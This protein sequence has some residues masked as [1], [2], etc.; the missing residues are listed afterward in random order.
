MTRKMITGRTLRVVDP[1]I[2]P[3]SEHRLRRLFAREDEL[4]AE[5]AKVRA[6]QREARNDY[7]SERG[8]L[9]RPGLAQVRK[10]LG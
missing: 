9:M 8:L 6:E 1:D 7:A 4:L 10:V 5:L 2:A 3:S